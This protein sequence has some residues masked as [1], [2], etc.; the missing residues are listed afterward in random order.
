M[1]RNKWQKPKVTS[2]YLIESGESHL[3]LLSGENRRARFLD[4]FILHQGFAQR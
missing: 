3:Y 1:T 2:G 4:K